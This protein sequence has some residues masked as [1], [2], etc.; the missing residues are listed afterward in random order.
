MHPEVSSA[1]ALGWLTREAMA[2]FEVDDSPEL[3]TA[4]R[5]LAEAMAAVS[6]VVVP[7]ELEP[8]VP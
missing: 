8:R 7:D 6:T 1:E 5:P 2:S 3:Q 4:L